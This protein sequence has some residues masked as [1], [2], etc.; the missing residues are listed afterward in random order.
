METATLPTAPFAAHPVVSRDPQ[1]MGGRPVFPGTRVPVAVLLEYL[2]LGHSIDEFLRQTP[3][4]SR[5]QAVRYPRAAHT[6]MVRD[7]E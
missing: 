6:R 3:T 2:E 1:I 7:E 5:D 4:V